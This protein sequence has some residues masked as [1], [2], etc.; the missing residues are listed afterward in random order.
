MISERKLR[1][2]Q[3]GLLLAA[4]VLF[5]YYWFG[6]RSLSRWARELDKPTADAW[7]EL[8]TAAKGSAHVRSLDETVLKAGVQEMRQAAT[9]LQQAA[10]AAYVRT[11][12]DEETRKHLGEGFQ[13]L[14]FDKAKEQVSLE[15]RRAAEANKVA[16]IEPALRGLP[17]FNPDLPQPA[18]HWAQLAFAR[19]LLA[20]AI[21]AAP[22][23]VSNL[24]ILPVNSH[25]QSEGLQV[26]YELPMRL[27][28]AGSP[29]N[30]LAFLA[31]LPLRGEEFKAAGLPEV[32]GKTQP[33]FM[34][35]LIL[36]NVQPY[37]VEAALEIV[38]VGFCELPKT[39]ATR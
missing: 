7:K 18:L 20:V 3:L 34:D 15:L 8:V 36:K 9:V 27:E 38:V 28:L 16:V 19:Q 1:R 26:L 22:R 24:T 6:Y 29:T 39:E 33:L 35:R 11:A 23:A 14:D 37:P 10:R 13:L 31:G 5:A 21:A 2:F 12:L 25:V 32:A 30:L 4:G 17:E